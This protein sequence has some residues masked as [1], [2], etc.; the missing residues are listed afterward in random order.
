M[1]LIAAE[2]QIVELNRKNFN[3]CRMGQKTDL[4]SHAVNHGD[5]KNDQYWE[6]GMLSRNSSSLTVFSKLNSQA[7]LRAHQS[8]ATSNNFD[9]DENDV[10]NVKR[11]NFM[12]NNSEVQIHFWTKEAL[13]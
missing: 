8:K 10:G 11:R 4:K 6:S 7:R 9:K 5:T 3:L 12:R 13:M 1:T 2:S